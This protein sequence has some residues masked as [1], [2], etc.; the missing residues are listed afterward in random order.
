MECDFCNKMF[1]NKFNLKQVSSFLNPIKNGKVSQS[2][3][4]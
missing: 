2:A 3:N 4:V 1:S